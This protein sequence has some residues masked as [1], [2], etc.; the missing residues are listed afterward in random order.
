MIELARTPDALRRPALELAQLQLHGVAFGSPTGSFPRGR[1]IEVTLCPIVYSLLFDKQNDKPKLYLDQNGDPIAFAK[2]VDS[3]LDLG[4]GLLHF[5]EHVSFGIEQGR[6]MRFSL[7]GNA[8]RP[9]SDIASVEQLVVAFGSPDKLVRTEANGDVI[10]FD[11]Y[12]EGARKWV[13]WDD[14]R[15]RLAFI[16]LGGSREDVRA[17]TRGA[18]LR[19]ELTPPEGRWSSG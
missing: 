7:Y 8:L 3:V 4:D 10:C 11:A 6:V 2:V 18:I 5:A 14:W 9:F 12:Y 19:R 1:V 13:R 17:G 15:R 16:A